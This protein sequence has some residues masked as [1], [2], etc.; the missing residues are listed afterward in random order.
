MPAQ[1]DRVVRTYGMESKGE[2][3][4]EKMWWRLWVPARAD[5]VVRPYGVKS[6]GGERRR[7]EKHRGLYFP[8]GNGREIEWPIHYLIRVRARIFGAW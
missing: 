8:P 1:A 3:A 2:D 4:V 6:V 5:R 7:E